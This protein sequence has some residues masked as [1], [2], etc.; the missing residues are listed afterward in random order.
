MQR[1]RGSDAFA[2]YS[3][4]PS[5]PF[6]TLK[7]AIY[8]PTRK[9]DRFDS[10]EIRG[11]IE[12]GIEVAGAWRAGLR[13]LRVPLDL[14]HPVWVSDPDYLPD[15]HIFEA[16]LPS[17]GGKE[18]LCDFLS[19]LMGQPLPRDRPL[20]QMWIIRGLEDRKIAIAFKV[21]HALADG[22]TIARL[23]Q[24][25]HTL[26]SAS[27]EENEP[28]I[29]QE[30]IPATYRLVG[31]A[32]VDLFKSYA[33]EFPNFYRYL[34]DARRRGEAIRDSSERLVAPFSAPFTILNTVEV[35]GPER[36]YRYESFSLSEFKALSRA[37]DCTINTLVM[38]ICSE[39]LKRYLAEQDAL[40]AESLIAAMPIGDQGGGGLERLL[41]SDIHNNNLAVAV[42][43]LY[44]NIGDFRQRL[45]EIKEAA[46]AAINHVKHDEGRRFDNYLDFLPGTAIRL[47]NAAMTRRQRKR[48]NPHGNVVISNVPGPRQTLYALD[49]RLE[50]EEL[51][52]VGNIA[53]QGHINIT[54]W[55]YVDN[56]AFSFFIRKH[57]LPE[58]ERMIGHLRDVVAELRDHYLAASE[59]PG[60]A[61][62]ERNT[63]GRR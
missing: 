12:Q 63:A 36:L 14:H 2:I 53:D 7:V 11:F 35:G 30:P 29:I 43:P 27:G 55:S 60:Q 56:I 3:E 51:L 13:I 9:N 15:N 23:I 42:L 18:Q 22:K 39:A 5:S 48:K 31:D 45:H 62:A 4:T 32:M 54:V 52:S 10:G 37:F 19:D 8:R 61:E 57:A 50:M 24:K 17:P 21:H 44:Q 47:V 40:P 16:E 41:N 28:E 20:W 25:A 1:L 58:P 46:L 49:G 33:V 34:K 6:V 59:A 26:S 38:G